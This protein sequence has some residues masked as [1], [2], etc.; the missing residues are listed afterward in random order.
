MRMEEVFSIAA[1][2]AI[3]LLILATFIITLVGAVLL[4]LFMGVGQQE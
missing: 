3:F 1:I 4:G 2:Q